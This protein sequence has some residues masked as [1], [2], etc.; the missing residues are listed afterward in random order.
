MKCINLRTRFGRKYRVTYEESYRAQY[1][2]RARIEDPALMVLLCRYGHIYPFGDSRLA[3][4]V[5]GHPN[6]AGT[7]RRMTCCEVWQD[8]D[9]GDLTVLFD[10]ADFVQIA[11]IMKP[12]RKYRPNYSAEQ[13]QA[14]GRRLQVARQA[15]LQQ[16]P[17]GRH[18][19]GMEELRK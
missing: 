12:Q 3:A 10:A 17:T 11:L 8:G 18:G 1:G 19:A 13:R 15:T 14:M 6:V 5:A 4:F 16:H 2:P 7:L 9:D